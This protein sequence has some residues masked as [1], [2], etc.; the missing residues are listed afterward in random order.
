[1]ETLTACGVPDARGTLPGEVRLF[2]CSR[3]RDSAQAAN[4]LS[5]DIVLK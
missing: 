5:P 2:D 3:D 1:M 4:V